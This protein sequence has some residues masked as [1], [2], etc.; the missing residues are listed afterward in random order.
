MPPPPR[1]ATL[2]ECRTP[3][4]IAFDGDNHDRFSQRLA[5]CCR[6]SRHGGGAIACDGIVVGRLASVDGSVLLG[7][8][9][10]NALD[11]VLEFRK[12]PPIGSGAD[13]KV[14]LGRGGQIDSVPETCGFLWSENPG[15]EFS[16]GYLNESGVAV[17]SIQCLSRE[18]GYDA[19]VARGEIRHGG[20]GYMLRRL[21][22]QRADSA[23]EG[24]S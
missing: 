15:L 5:D 7:H 16:D 6:D 18:D 10:E 19:L 12:I 17:V 22:A 14:D 13:G 2:V 20:I 3:Q 9:E 4:R 24:M 1:F 21:V 23:R 11:R 8:N